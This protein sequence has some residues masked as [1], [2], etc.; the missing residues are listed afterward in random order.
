MFYNGVSDTPV[1]S[2]TACSAPIINAA[3]EIV[4]QDNSTLYLTKTGATSVVSTSKIPVRSKTGPAKVLVVQGTRALSGDLFDLRGR[5]MTSRRD[6]VQI[7]IL[8]RR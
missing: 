7:G 1:C 5:R 3:Y 6:H 8:V 2:Y 4:W